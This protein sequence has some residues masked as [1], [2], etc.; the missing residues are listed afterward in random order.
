[1]IVERVAT[2]RLQAGNR[3]DDGDQCHLYGQ[4]VLGDATCPPPTV[5]RAIVAARIAGRVAAGRQLLRLL[6]VLAR[7]QQLRC[8][9][10]GGRI[11][12]VG[13]SGC[14]RRSCCRRAGG[15]VLAPAAAV[16]GSL[17]GGAGLTAVHR[18][19]TKENAHKV[20]HRK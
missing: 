9:A 13:V 3:T 19:Q 14:V 7:A 6:L 17:A 11:S 18:E 1:M 5:G 8:T 2:V 15:A 16:V 12:A 20:T 4:R 10:D